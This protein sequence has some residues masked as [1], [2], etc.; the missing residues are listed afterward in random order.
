MRIYLNPVCDY[1]RGFAKWKK[2]EPELRLRYPGLSVEKIQSPDGF[3]VQIQKA[4]DGGERNFVAAGG[5]GT[6]NLLLDSLLCY[7]PSGRDFRLGAIGL[8]S[9]NDFHKPFKDRSMI[10]R[11]PVRLDFEKAVACDVIAVHYRNGRRGMR[12]RYC[13]VNASIGITAEANAFYNSRRPFIAF[14]KNFCHEAAVVASALRTIF[15]YSNIPCSVR[16]EQGGEIPLSLTNV[17]VIK[18][19]HFAG[20]LCYDTAVGI[21]DGNMGINLCVGMTRGEAVKTLARLYR[22]EFQGQSKTISQL[23]RMFSVMSRRRFA[24]EIDGEV[25]TTEEA[26]FAV[27]PRLVR[28]C[29]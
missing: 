19:A 21:D 3:G 25:V 10:R 23:G 7:S 26:R 29:P 22:R 1:G 13:L 8:G 11:I 27:R 28:C 5:D 14:L 16:F 15:W 24:L 6:V 18:N 17:G 9:S 12:I 2:I 20:G 4:L